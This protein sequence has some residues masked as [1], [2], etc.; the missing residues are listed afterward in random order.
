MIHSFMRILVTSTKVRSLFGQF[1]KVLI[2]A[3]YFHGFYAMFTTASVMFLCD[4][5]PNVAPTPRI[6]QFVIL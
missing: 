1:I 4:L 6:L 2:M 5:D 3:Y